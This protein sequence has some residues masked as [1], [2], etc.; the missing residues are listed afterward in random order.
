MGF[1]IRKPKLAQAAGKGFITKFL[2]HAKNKGH[3]KVAVIVVLILL[4]NEAYFP[5]GN[6]PA[7]KR[8][9]VSA[10]GSVAYLGFASAHLT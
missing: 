6:L 5:Q 2:Q 1:T 3:M 7:K 4:T 10:A 9:I 8:K